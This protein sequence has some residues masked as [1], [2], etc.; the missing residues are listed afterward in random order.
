[1]RLSL[2]HDLHSC[3]VN[4]KVIFL[5]ALAGRYFCLPGR[6]EGAFVE[7]A[8]GGPINER[9][10]EIQEMIG[11]GLLIVDTPNPRPLLPDPDP[12]ALYRDLSENRSRPSLSDVATAA[13][14]QARAAIILRTKRFQQ[15]LRMLQSSR[16]AAQAL[17]PGNDGATA[18]RLATALQATSLLFGSSDRC[19][20]RSL[21]LLQLCY[22]RGSTPTFVIG[23]RTNPF[24]AHC[25]V[26]QGDLVLNDRSEHARLFARIFA[27]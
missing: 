19:L 23:V 11:R 2:G 20:N 21:A 15:I 14:A 26:Q 4:G 12:P 10:P 6:L 16:N 8:R 1:M 5:D 25:W 3:M 18:I 13:A 7:A 27:L 24:V 9:G 22:R 17:Q